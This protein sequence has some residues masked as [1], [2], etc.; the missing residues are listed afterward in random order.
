M[1]RT[2]CAGA[3]RR[4]CF[5]VVD[6]IVVLCDDCQEC[7]VETLK[8]RKIRVDSFSLRLTAKGWKKAAA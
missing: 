2:R 3:F 4:V 1:S 5:A 6:P 7:V 8:D